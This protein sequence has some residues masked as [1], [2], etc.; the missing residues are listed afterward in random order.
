[1][2]EDAEHRLRQDK[3]Q[4]QRR[5]QAEGQP[6]PRGR[7]VVVMVMAAVDMAAMPVIMPIIVVVMIVGTMMMVVL[8]HLRQYVLHCV[9]QLWSLLSGFLTT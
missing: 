9:A 5:A 2:S 4:I 6:E 3:A 7:V 8:A 1:M